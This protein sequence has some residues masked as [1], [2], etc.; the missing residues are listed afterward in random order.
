MEQMK[1]VSYKTDT[2]QD[3][4]FYSQPLVHRP[5][6]I[7]NLGINDIC[8]NKNIVIQIVMCAWQLFLHDQINVS[9]RYTPH[10]HFIASNDVVVSF[11]ENL[12]ISDC[13]GLAI[14]SVMGLKRQEVLL[15]IGTCGQIRRCY[16]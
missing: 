9:H 10:L 14:S 5:G 7:G 3:D 2:I 12:N 16:L 8:R 11:K 6:I 1:E 15:Q 13:L 4:N